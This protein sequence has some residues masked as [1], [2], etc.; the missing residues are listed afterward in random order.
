MISNQNT[1]IGPQKG[2]FLK[3]GFTSLDLWF[4]KV[5]LFPVPDLQI[6]QSSYIQGTHIEFHLKSTY[7]DVYYIGLN[8]IEIFDE[9]GKNVLTEG[10]DKFT[11]QAVPPG[12]YI[13][14]NMA[15]D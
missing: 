6:Q 14:K 10:K 4:E 5:I 2:I 12:V 13:D 3:K 8:E 9:L 1:I 15:K 7:G 11:I